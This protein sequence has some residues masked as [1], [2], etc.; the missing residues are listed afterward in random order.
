MECPRLAHK[1]GDM[2]ASDKIMQKITERLS[3]AQDDPE[4]AALRQKINAFAQEN[5]IFMYLHNEVNSHD[6]SVMLLERTAALKTEQE[7]DAA[8]RE[9]IF[10]L[11][12]QQALTRIMALKDLQSQNKNA[13]L[14]R[15]Y[16]RKM[17][18]RL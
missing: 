14:Y 17:V 5:P 11:M 10:D 9:R 7:E 1:L 15:I 12:N 8:A 16:P 4:E 3:D 13:S 6:A 18:L 2:S